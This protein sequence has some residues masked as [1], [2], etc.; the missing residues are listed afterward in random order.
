M[1]LKVDVVES[2]TCNLVIDELCTIYGN[3]V[4]LI[5]L[6]ELLGLF[7]KSNLSSWLEIKKVDI[8]AIKLFRLHGIKHIMKKS[9]YLLLQRKL[10]NDSN[11]HGKMRYKATTFVLKKFPNC[12]T[13]RK[14]DSRS[15]PQ[16]H[17]NPN[18]PTL[19]H[20]Y[21][22]IEEP[23]SSNSKVIRRIKQ[24]QLLWRHSTS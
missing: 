14:S 13:F 12:K 23:N 24:R 16:S 1:I 4:L 17:L 9:S 5:I 18:I 21:L 2:A 7:T 8:E 15:K 22:E 3:N 11:G 20:S 10:F 6:G 19:S